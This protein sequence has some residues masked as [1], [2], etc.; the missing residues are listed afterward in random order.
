MCVCVPTSSCPFLTILFSLISSFPFYPSLSLHHHHHY[1][2]SPHITSLHQYLPPSFPPPPLPNN[3]PTTNT[4]PPFKCKEVPNLGHYCPTQSTNRTRPDMT[5]H[6]KAKGRVSSQ[7]VCD[8][9]PH[10]F[11]LTTT[12]SWGYNMKL[13]Q[14][15]GSKLGAALSYCRRNMVQRMKKLL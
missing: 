13:G 4:P 11:P 15:S 8:F 5:R 14:V 10:S 6:T 7:N 9:G 12:S 3:K 1:F 2:A